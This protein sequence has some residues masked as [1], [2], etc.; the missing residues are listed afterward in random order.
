[1]EEL[2]YQQVLADVYEENAKD[3]LVC[4]NDNYSDV[5]AE[6]KH[7]DEI[8]D[9]EAFRREQIGHQV[10][11]V[12]PDPPKYED[13]TTQSIKY[14]METQMTVLNIDSKFR[15]NR[16]ESPSNFICRLLTPI[17]NVISV[18]VSSIEVP[19][20]FYAFS[21]V[22][23]NVS[24]YL[25]YPSGTT[26][27]LI[28]IGDGNY[29]QNAYPDASSILTAVQNAMNAAFPTA[30]F[31]LTIDLVTGLLS[32]SS[33][34]FPYYDFDVNFIPS[35]DNLISREYGLGYN[36]G[37]RQFTYTSTRLTSSSAISAEAILNTTDTNYIFLSLDND[38]KVT[39]HETP[40]TIQ[41]SAF[42]K[43]IINSAKN[44][45]TY[46]NGSDTITR[47]YFFQQPTNISSFQVRLSDPYDQ[48]IDLVGLDFSFTLELRTV[49]NSS[50]YDSMRGLTQT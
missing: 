18:R 45:F 27:V 30:I 25:A 6:D 34:A 2:T 8:E 35:T 29:N 16:L 28:T 11:S 4:P 50:L 17:K 46:E 7:P 26:P 42:S 33:T 32:I 5:A 20:S 41:L 9:Q 36:L 13:R 44:Q 10:A 47:E 31:S 23:N 21:A 12:Q 48:D 38:W 24:F 40:R 1:M 14:R 43:I 49:M 37:F 22:R 19:N 15:E 39:R 3:T